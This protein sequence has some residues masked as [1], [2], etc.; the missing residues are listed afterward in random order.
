M[1]N[2]EFQELLEKL[3]EA[4]YSLGVW[5]QDYSSEAE[6]EEEQDEVFRGAKDAEIYLREVEAE[7]EVYCKSNK[8][9]NSYC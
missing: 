8:I 9:R 2:I 6:T 5:L 7:V 1:K 3:A 4:E